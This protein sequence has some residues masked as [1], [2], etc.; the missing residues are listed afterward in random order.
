[1]KTVF[2]DTNVVIDLLDKRENFYIDALKIFTKAYN[3]EIKVFI[4]PI[5]YATASYVLR[6]HEKS[7]LKT[8][9]YNLRQLV[10]ISICD[11]TV[12]DSSLESDFEDFEDAM[13]FF[14]ALLSNAEVI[15]TR[16]KKDFYKSTIKVMTPSEFL[17]QS[18]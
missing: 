14:C 9:L 1:M 12:I 8:L 11:E 7:E 13:Q 6:K 18:T 15:V 2:L 10:S 3:K 4:S 16:N 17:S 5:T